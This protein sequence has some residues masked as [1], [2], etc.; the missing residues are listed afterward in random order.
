M[1]RQSLGWHVEPK[2]SLDTAS[3]SPSLPRSLQMQHRAHSLIAPYSGRC[4]GK[5]R[6]GRDHDFNTRYGRCSQLDKLST[7]FRLHSWNGRIHRQSE[8]GSFATFVRPQGSMR[9]LARRMHLAFVVVPS[10]AF[11]SGPNRSPIRHLLGHEPCRREQLLEGSPCTT[12]VLT[13]L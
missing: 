9:L 1:E 4:I 7:S 12:V 5:S 6:P 3:V 10:Q 13:S 11:C 8:L 2:F